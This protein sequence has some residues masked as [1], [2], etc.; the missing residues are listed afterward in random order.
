MKVKNYLELVNGPQEE[1]LTRIRK[2]LL[3]LYCHGVEAVS[4]YRA[5]LGQLQLNYD[6]NSLQ[7][8]N[9]VLKLSNRKLW[10]LGA[11]KATGKMAE[12]LESLLEGKNYSGLVIVPRGVKKQLKLKN[13]ECCESD[14]PIPSPKNLE[15]TK[16]LIEIT[17]NIE[18]QDLVFFLLSGGGSALL[19]MPQVPLEDFIELNKQLIRSNMNIHEINVIRKHVSGIKGGKLAR[20]IKAK[21]KLVLVIS[22][23]IGDNLETIASGPMVAD[24]STYQDAKKILRMHELWGKL[25]KSVEKVI[26]QGIKGLLEE[27]PKQGN[28]VFDEV[29]PFIIASNKIACEAIMRKTN[30]LNLQSTFLTDKIEGDARTLGRLMVRL[31]E[32]FSGTNNR[33]MIFISGGEPTVEVKGKGIGGRNQELVASAMQEFRFCKGD[34]CFL[35]AGTDGIDGNSKY[36]GAIIDNF[37]L[38]LLKSKQLPLDRY[39]AD[40]DLTTFFEKLGSSLLETGPTGTN[41]MD[42]QL[43]YLLKK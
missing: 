37:S 30:E 21:D 18:R 32:G 34:F 6:K 31:Y 15:N 1:E 8:K 24:P 23:V 26:E 43:C 10:V 33:A 20:L 42:I 9:L 3:D 14:H 4:P 13:I 41:V 7:I 38:E 27:T 12:A 35:S 40:N 22:D 2:L 5:V 17:K 29:K 19:T 25:P 28:H 16:K 11:G 39:L 36:A